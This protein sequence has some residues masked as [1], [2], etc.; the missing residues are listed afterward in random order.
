M[1]LILQP[2]YS[3]RIVLISHVIWISILTSASYGLYFCSLLALTVWATSQIYWSYPVKG[4]RRSLDMACASASLIYHFGLSI[5]SLTKPQLYLSLLAVALSFYFL[6][7]R[8]QNQNYSSFYHCLMHIFG[9][10]S[11]LVLYSSLAN[12]KD[13]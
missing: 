3:R 12:E 11:N 7:R 2:E 13:K 9:N 10:I 8:A 5:S 4:L 1:I 6:A